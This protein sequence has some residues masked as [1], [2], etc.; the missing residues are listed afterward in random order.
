M[1]IQTWMKNRMR[2]GTLADAARRA[3]AKDRV[4]AQVEETFRVMCILEA[5]VKNDGSQKNAAEALGITVVTLRRTTRSR[6]L[7]CSDL[8]AITKAL[9]GEGSEK[10]AANSSS[11]PVT[12]RA[13]ASRGRSNGSPIRRENLSGDGLRSNQ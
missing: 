8:R 1:Q 7:F 12:P 10:A 2:P 4:L 13:A 6:G 11:A 3:M 9:K 5:I